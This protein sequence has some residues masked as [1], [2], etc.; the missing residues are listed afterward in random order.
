MRSWVLLLA[1]S[2]LLLTGGAAALSRPTADPH[3]P[4][5]FWE[6]EGGVVSSNFH[7]RRDGNR[8]FYAGSLKQAR[9]GAF[10]FT[11]L[12]L[13]YNPVDFSFKK[14][15][16]LAVFY[17]GHSSGFEAEAQS[18]EESAAG[19]LSATIT[20]ECYNPTYCATPP[21]DPSHPWG[22]YVLLL[23]DKRSLVAPVKTL[24]V[25]TA[26]G[27][28]PA[29][30][31]LAPPKPPTLLTVSQRNRHPSATFSMP[32]SDEATIYFA[33]KPG[34]A[35]DGGFLR[36]NIKELDLLGTVEIRRG[37]WSFEEQ[38]DPGTYYVMMQAIDYGCIGQPGCIGGYSN[39]LT[40]AV[41]KPSQT[42]RGSVEVLHDVHIVSLTL[43]VTAL[44]EKLP[45]KVCWQLATGKRRCVSGT[46]AGYSWNSSADNQLSVG[47]RGM[48]ARTKFTWY[49]RGHAVVSKT[50]NTV[51]R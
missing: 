39:M 41:P 11:A 26:F 10:R 28:A 38:L 40:L 7:P 13:P 45:Y 2:A 34:R 4:V 6:R 25:T 31:E 3:Q 30:P 18:V 16:V 35:S 20:L 49:V 46:V 36:K 47:L 9:K 17:K 48:K 33:S 27:T 1:I 8:V 32:G 14:Y 12:G 51:R 42:Y 29:P 24:S 37:S 22:I 5:S 15:G 21:Y 44:R 19:N 43:H 23:I 50:A